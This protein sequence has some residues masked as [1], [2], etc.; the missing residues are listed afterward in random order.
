MVDQAR[1]EQFVQ[2]LRDWGCVFML[3][4]WLQSIMASGIAKNGSRDGGRSKYLKTRN[5]LMKKEIGAVWTE[6]KREFPGEITA[7]E[8]LAA[9]MIILIRN[10]LAHCLIS[11]GKGLALFLPKERRQE[12]IKRLISAGW[13]GVPDDA[14]FDP[15]MLVLREGDR[16]WF[17]RNTSMILNF[18]DNTVLRL[19]RGHGIEDLAIC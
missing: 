5:N 15:A 1:H 8:E 10:Q 14:A 19:T 13:I 16:E 6:F 18:A 7:Q 4:V 17:D 3:A 9:H 11:S 12:R 2:S